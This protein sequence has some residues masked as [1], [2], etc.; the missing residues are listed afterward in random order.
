MT[1]RQLLRTI[2]TVLSPRQ[3]R[4]YV[5]FQFFFVIAGFLQVVG[6][7]S[8]A[9]FVALLSR[10][11]IMHT[12]SFAAAIYETVGFKSDV[13]AI[14]AFAVL[15][16]VV[17]AVS[18]V[19]AAVSVW[20]T[21]R[22]SLDL[23]ADL[24]RDLLMCYLRRDYVQLAGT[25][26]S[27]LINKVT[28]GAPRFSFNVMLPLMIIANQAAVVLVII[29][30]LS[31][32]QPLVVLVFASL[33][34]GAYSLL[35]LVVKRRLSF[36]G[37]RVWRNHRKKHR[38][39]T[40]SLGGLKEIRL[41]GTENQYLE[42]F[43]S[44]VRESDRSETIVGTL[45]DV[46]RFLLETIAFTS[47]L[48]LAV[49]MLL[50]G[51]ESSTVIAVLSLYAVT[52]YRM[53]PAAQSIFKAI[54]QIRSNTKTL[55][56]ILPDVLEGRKRAAELEQ[57]DDLSVPAYPAEVR[58]RGVAFTYPNGKDAVLHEISTTLP[59][60]ALTVLVGHSGS[61]KSTLADILLGLLP[62]S[63]GEVTVGGVAVGAMGKEWF[64]AV[65]YVPQSIFLVDDTIATNVSFGSPLGLQPERLHRALKLARLDEFVATLPEGV[66]YHIGERG[67]RL[68]G[69]QRQRIGLARALYH[70]ANF[71]LLDEAT[72]ALDG[73]T[74]AEIIDTL[75]EL[76][77]N[78]TV[79][80]IAHRLTTIQAADHI[81]LL[82]NGRIEAEGSWSSLLESSD[83]FR[84]LVQLGSRQ[85]NP[86]TV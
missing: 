27:E 21:F 17:L 3:R 57:R 1:F 28:I 41:S 49:Y 5:A 26:S 7:G 10:P 74:E 62:P 82:N 85:D 67:A 12:N 11:E 69:G 24:Q 55:T 83:A 19:V 79:V 78:H 6:A 13:Q 80:M 33:I 31:F 9:P 65:G 34:G 23:G 4:R 76:R 50:T 75:L 39:L 84:G 14:V 36:H 32:Y 18:N 54:S 71:L 16:V 48:L 81:I 72:S 8:V 44:V 68:S 29:V 42:Q 77:E 70:D 2:G 52:G 43:N 37:D 35:F 64:R 60:N 59:I 53:L 56:D 40:E 20:L 63:E 30:G 86:V 22:F 38:L 66:N 58:F 51:A 61:G 47:L 25:N 45:G 15:M 73:K 46:P